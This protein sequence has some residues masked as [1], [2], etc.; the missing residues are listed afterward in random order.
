M[1]NKGTTETATNAAISRVLFSNFFVGPTTNN[2][3][4]LKKGKN[5]QISS[6]KGNPIHSS[7]TCSPPTSSPT[8]SQ[9]H[10]SSSPTN[11]LNTSSPPFPILH[12][13]STHIVPPFHNSTRPRR[14]PTL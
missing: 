10:S 3:I 12:S 7:S 14:Q 9:L 5:A 1:Q 13:F 8:V 11:A 4:S 2:K 6:N